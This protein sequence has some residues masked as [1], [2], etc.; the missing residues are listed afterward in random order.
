MIDC[1][2]HAE[3]VKFKHIVH[4][5]ITGEVTHNELRHEATDDSDNS[6][7]GMGEW[8]REMRKESPQGGL[9]IERLDLGAFH[10]YQ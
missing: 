6:D 10:C 1:S 5:V 9:R 2:V 4:T 7:G 3:T 8:L